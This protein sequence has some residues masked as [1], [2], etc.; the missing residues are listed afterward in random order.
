MNEVIFGRLLFCMQVANDKQKG[1]LMRSQQNTFITSTEHLLPKHSRML[2]ASCGAFKYGFVCSVFVTV[3]TVK[4]AEV[5][6]TF[7]TS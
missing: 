5:L 2:K 6:K 7:P 4:L 1:Q 3:C